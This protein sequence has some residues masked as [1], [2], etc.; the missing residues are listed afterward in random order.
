[1][2]TPPTKL[3]EAGHAGRATD[4]VAGEGVEGVESMEV[5]GIKVPAKAVVEVR[6][7]SNV[8][9]NEERDEMVR[10]AEN[11]VSEACA[12]EGWG[13]DRVEVHAGERWG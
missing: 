5:E 1:M 11:D 10:V 9:S 7:V 13:K 8:L 4:D 12:G 6:D 2:K 3:P